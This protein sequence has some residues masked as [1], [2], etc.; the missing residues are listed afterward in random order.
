MPQT[1]DTANM[2]GYVLSALAA[3]SLLLAV[4]VVEKCR[5]NG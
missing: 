4:V 1:G 2:M 3:T 5:R